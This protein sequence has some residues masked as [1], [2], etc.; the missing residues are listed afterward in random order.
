M[1]STTQKEG[2]VPLDAKG[3]GNQQLYA[4]EGYANV[5]NKAFGEGWRDTPHGKQ[6]LDLAQ[7]VTNW[8][9]GVLMGMSA[10]HGITMA[11]ESFINQ[12]TLGMQQ[13]ARDPAL[14]IKTLIKS[15]IGA[16]T[17]YRSGKLGAGDW[18]N[19]TMGPKTSDL[20]KGL[21]D[22]NARAIGHGDPT[23][24][25]KAGNVNAVKP[26]PASNMWDSFSNAL[27]QTKDDITTDFKDAGGNPIKLGKATLQ[28][29]GAAMQAITHP[30]FQYAIPNLKLG[31]FK[32][33]FGEWMKQNPGTGDPKVDDGV[34]ADAAQKIWDDI[35]NRFGL[36]T[37]DNLMWNKKLKEG[38]QLGM[39]SPTWSIG[40]GRNVAGGLAQGIMHPTR[41]K[42]SSPEYDPRIGSALGL[43]ITTSIMSAAY[44]YLKTG[45][46][47]TDINDLMAGRTGGKTAAGQPERGILP[48]FQKDV[49]GWM[50]DPVGEA[51]NKLGVVPKTILES[52]TNKGWAQTDKGPRYG[53]ISNPNHTVGD[54][55]KE[56]AL[57]AAHN[58]IPITVQQQ[59]KATN[60]GSNITRGE[61]ALAVREAPKQINPGGNKRENAYLDKEWK[62]THPNQ[63]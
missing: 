45:E 16:A 61:R 55:L 15:P 56:R 54:Q 26:T 5:F 8:G 19:G 29:V 27:K 4:K 50:H 49:Y 35:E 40:F 62:Q 20:I 10:F 11:N 37:N 59:L 31:A 41:F 28:G 57:H 43:G 9:T 46:A 25:F 44:Q 58:F 21:E 42:M 63:K 38:L 36:M 33:N 2:W 23:Y 17:L 14:G 18:L 48:G 3:A 30:L 6:F 60:P 24:Q 47:P 22:A 52:A 39:T 1:V 13:M 34:N 32:E 51:Y 12:V 53:L 7:P